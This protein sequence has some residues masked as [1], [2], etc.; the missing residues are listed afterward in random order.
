MK[1]LIHICVVGLL[2]GCLGWMG[3]TQSVSALDLNYN[4]QKPSSQ[5]LAMDGSDEA[6]DE[7]ELELR[8][9]ID[10]LRLEL[11]QKAEVAKPGAKSAPAAPTVATKDSRRNAVDDKLGT[12]FGKKI[13]LNNTNVRAFRQFPGLY[14]TL[15]GL[16]V[17]N[18][19]YKEVDDILNL[20]GL[21][22][23]Q[24]QT[25]KDN[26]KNFT[27]TDPENALVEGGDRFNNGIYK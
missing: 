2:I 1:R 8:Q 20:P 4:L 6:A 21:T 13:D 22:D 25:L 24:K 10:E 18:A 3:I 14:P 26:F 7:T 23:R 11:R 27:V 19:P 16:V 15:A 5:L 12:E 17:D 9:K